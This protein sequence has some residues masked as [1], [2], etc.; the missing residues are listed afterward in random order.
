M[1]EFKMLL[2]VL[3]HETSYV[4]ECNVFV[5]NLDSLIKKLEPYLAD[6]HKVCKGIHLCSNSRLDA[7]RRI[8]LLYVK[9]TL[10]QA[11]GLVSRYSYLLK[12]TSMFF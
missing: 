3:C 12:I 10:D 5:D 1:R 8:G 7:F 9:R 6:A 4:D 11:E 2:K